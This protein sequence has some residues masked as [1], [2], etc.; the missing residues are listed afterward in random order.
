MEV[1]LGTVKQ[2]AFK[3]KA[4]LTLSPQEVLTQV[5]LLADTLDIPLHQA[6]EMAAIQ[7]GLLFDTVVS[8]SWA[9]I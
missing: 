2:M 5:Q 6:K 4:L 7:P 8:F 1:P 9:L 3:R